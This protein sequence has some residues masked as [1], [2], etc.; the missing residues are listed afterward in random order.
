VFSAVDLNHDGIVD[1]Y[2]M[3]M[4]VRKPFRPAAKADDKDYSLKNANLILAFDYKLTGLI[5]MKLEALAVVS[6]DALVEDTLNAGK[7]T[8]YG[9]LKLR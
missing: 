8:T 3:T 1:Q 2:N 7:I 9:D 5:K 6:I 4:R